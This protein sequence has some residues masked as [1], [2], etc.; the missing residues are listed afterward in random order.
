MTV[1]VPTGRQ[2]GSGSHGEVPQERQL[3]DLARAKREQTPGLVVCFPS[4]M[5]R[6]AFT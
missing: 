6:F 4:R 2:L 3:R 1:V 5:D